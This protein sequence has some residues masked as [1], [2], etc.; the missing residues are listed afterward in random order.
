MTQQRLMYLCVVLTPA[1]PCTAANP[2]KEEE[3]STQSSH[4]RRALLPG[5]TSWAQQATVLRLQ[6]SVISSDGN[7]TLQAELSAADGCPAAQVRQ[8]GSTRRGDGWR[9]AVGA[10]G[11]GVCVGGGG[12]RGKRGPSLPCTGRP[13]CG[14]LLTCVLLCASARCSS[15]GAAQRTCTSSC[16]ALRPPC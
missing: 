2:T 15:L 13:F 6:P 5:Q 10:P 11:V 16:E 9:T 7:S 12:V 14:R 1:L 3:Q 8:P 4:A